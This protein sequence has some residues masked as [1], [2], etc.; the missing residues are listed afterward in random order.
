MGNSH[1]ACLRQ[2]WTKDAGR[3]PGITPL[4]VGGHRNLLLD[5]AQVARRLVPTSD[6][7]ARAFADLSGIDHIDLDA[8]DAFVI[9]GCLVSLGCIA[10]L[11]RDA[12]WLDLPS[13]AAHDDLASDPAILMSD[14]AVQMTAE[15]ILSR[16]LGLRVAR[17]L[18]EMTDRPIVVTSQARVSAVIEKAHRPGTRAH[19]AALRAGD[20]AALSDLFEGSAARVCREAGATFLPQPRHTITKHILTSRP[21]MDGAVRLTA[22]GNTPQPPKDITHANARYGAA[23]LDQISAHFGVSADTQGSLGRAS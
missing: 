5:T 17:H 8:H 13:V 4:F 11:Y 19:H 12:R 14:A 21:Y 15:D 7:A 20:A 23:V 1:I 18:R 10:N 3:W 2:A 16:R 22:D 9:T 6:G